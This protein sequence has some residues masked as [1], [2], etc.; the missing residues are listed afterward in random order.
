MNTQK[1]TKNS[2]L[3]K[4]VNDCRDY[5]EEGDGQR[6]HVREG[7]VL[8]DGLFVAKN[9]ENGLMIGVPNGN[10][11]QEAVKILNFLDGVEITK[12]GKQHFLNGKA[13]DCTLSYVDQSSGDWEYKVD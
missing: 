8:L 6:I 13:W 10:I 7:V 5:G 3:N 2:K 4:L 1:S 9:S 11:R 12:S